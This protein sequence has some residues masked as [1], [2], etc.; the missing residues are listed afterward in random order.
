[1]IN[2]AISVESV[3]VTFLSSC[4]DMC[5]SSCALTRK[6]DWKIPV[7]LLW[8]P[9]F[10]GHS[11]V[12]ESQQGRLTHIGSTDKGHLAEGL[13]KA[14]FTLI[15]AM[16]PQPKHSDSLRLRSMVFCAVLTVKKQLKLTANHSQHC[17]SI[18]RSE[19]YPKSSWPLAKWIEYDRM[20]RMD[21]MDMGETWVWLCPN[22]GCHIMFHHVS[23]CFIMLVWRT[24]W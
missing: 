11:D 23:S 5:W 24:L 20:D 13:A 12:A 15:N 3:F 1:M 10:S 2:L 17:L 4:F 18:V 8:S 19:F 21:R 7:K 6:M 9:R 14:R 22:I 16:V